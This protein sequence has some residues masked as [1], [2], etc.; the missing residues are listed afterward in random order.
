MSA[1]PA[2]YPFPHFRLKSRV[3]FSEVRNENER[4]ETIAD[5]A[6]QHRHRRTVCSPWRNPAWHGR[7][8]AYLELLAGDSATIKLVLGKNE[9][10]TIDAAP[11]MVTS[12]VSTKQVNMLGGD[13]EETDDST[14]PPGY[15]E[16]AA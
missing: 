12:P 2:L 4:G 7:L 5:T 13:A 8:M 1:I 3:L 14:L 15:D 6:A 9:R 16:E 11:L 10:L